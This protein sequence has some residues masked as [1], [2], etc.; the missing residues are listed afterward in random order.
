MSNL[1][2]ENQEIKT[3][4]N[5]NKLH[6]ED[7][8]ICEQFNTKEVKCHG[9]LHST[10]EDVVLRT[11]GQHVCNNSA[12]NVFTQ[13]L[14]TGIKRKAEETMD[15][16]A[17]IRTRVLQQV[18]TPI[19]AN[20]PSKNAMK[21]VVKPS[22]NSRT[23]NSGGLLSSIHLCLFHLVKN[24]KKKISELVGRTQ[25]ARSQ[26]VRLSV[27]SLSVARTQLAALSWRLSPDPN[28]N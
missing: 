18:P 25:L 1:R 9:R 8:Y 22:I 14:I 20:L 21:K 17:A 24:M 5:Q 11:V 7:S 3:Q 27:G 6:H 28:R 26:L 15:T 13:R 19:L 16:P 10:M 2:M 12:A 4:R 23:S